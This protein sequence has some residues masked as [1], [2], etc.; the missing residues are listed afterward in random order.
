MAKVK[1]K[2][3]GKNGRIHSAQTVLPAPKPG[4]P[5]GRK[6]RTPQ[7]EFRGEYMSSSMHTMAEGTAKKFHEALNKAGEYMRRYEGLSSFA[8]KGMKAP[9]V[10]RYVHYLMNRYVSEHTGRPLTDKSIKD[11]LGQFRKVL[12]VLGKG[13]ML[14]DYE[15]YGL[16][17]TR[18]DLERPIKFPTRWEADRAAFQ[19]RMD[20]QATWIGVAAQLGLAFGLREQERI[21]SRDVLVKKDGKYF[22]TWKCGDEKEVTV[23]QLAERYGPTFRDRLG[24]VEEET[25]YLIV[26]GAKGGRNRPCEIYNSARS[27]AVDRVQAY[28]RGNRAEHRQ[29]MS[30]IPDR[31]TLEQGR[32]Q[33]SKAQ[34]RCGGT[35]ETLCHS[36]ADRHWDAQLL[37]SEGWDDQ[38]IVEDKGHS[39][40]RK[41]HYYID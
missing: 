32:A 10:E 2:I 34:E 31:F 6:Y 14:R 12:L 18:E 30:L 40:P 8:G 16:K 22:A 17:V 24:L 21:R 1:I 29:H 37:Q 39:D 13:H 27:E 25:R 36:H 3:K 35:K 26:Q 15:Y 41:I 20:G 4:G 9:H 7:A 11:L 23:R 38:A 19:Q 5:S 28:I 33:Y